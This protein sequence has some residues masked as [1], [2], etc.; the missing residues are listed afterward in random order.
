MCACDE[1]GVRPPRAHLP[2]VGTRPMAAMMR[3]KRSLSSRMEKVGSLGGSWKLLIS[4]EQSSN[5]GRK[6]VKR[7]WRL[8]ASRKRKHREE[9]NDNSLTQQSA[10]H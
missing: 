3:L 6:S 7:S 10:D 2:S 8:A 1:G 4:V 5:L 9:V